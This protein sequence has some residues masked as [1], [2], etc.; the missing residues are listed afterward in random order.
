MKINTQQFRVLFCALSLMCSC[1]AW[2][3]GEAAIKLSFPKDIDDHITSCCGKPV[4]GGIKSITQNSGGAWSMK[5][6]FD[7]EG[8]VVKISDIN[9]GKVPKYS[10]FKYNKQGHAVKKEYVDNGYKSS[11]TIT[12]DEQ[13]NPLKRITKEDGNKEEVSF[14][15]DFASRQVKATLGNSDFPK[16][17]YIFNEQGRVTSCQD[18][19]SSQMTRTT[20]YAYNPNGQIVRIEEI[21]ERDN[22]YEH[23]VDSTC[24]TFT[25]NAQGLWEKVEKNTCTIGQDKDKDGNVKEKQSS[26]KSAST[27]YSGYEIDAQGNVTRYTETSAGNKSR[28]VNRSIIYY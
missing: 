26:T 11:I 20:R 9:D 21:K 18:L 17:I 6:D 1:T 27:L 28:T 22:R 4:T 16:R 3:A 23:S 19:P 2:G 24:T 14:T 7:K 15:Y 5:I 25:F 10:Q 8:R 12:P 13:G